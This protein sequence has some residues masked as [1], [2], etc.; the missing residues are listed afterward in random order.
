[1]SANGNILFMFRFF[2]QHSHLETVVNSEYVGVC[3]ERVHQFNIV[4][5][6]RRIINAV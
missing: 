3:A 4:L 2:T 1:L 5:A 6:K